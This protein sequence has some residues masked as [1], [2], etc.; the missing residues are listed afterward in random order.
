MCVYAATRTCVCSHRS[1]LPESGATSQT[2][3]ILPALKEKEV[4]PLS[5]RADETKR[6]KG[7]AK[8]FKVC[9]S[10]D[11]GSDGLSASLV[12]FLGNGIVYVE[13]WF[14]V[15][16]QHIPGNLVEM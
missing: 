7:L 10:S 6:V 9:I 13:L 8:P 15:L 14:S 4:I 2:H 11:S 1:R 12:R 5:L 3:L 16:S